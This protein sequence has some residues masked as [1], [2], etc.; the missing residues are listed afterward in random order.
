MAVK[1]VTADTSLVTIATI[2]KHKKCVITAIN[3][4][5]QHTADEKIE[6]AD[7]FTT[8]TSNGAAGAAKEIYKFQATVSAG[9]TYSADKN[10]LED[11][12]C[13]GTPKLKGSVTNANCVSIVHYHWE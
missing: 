9:N 6:L 5:N 11:L 2:V 1:K 8:D 4:D 7:I 3:V 13:L 12:E 10:S